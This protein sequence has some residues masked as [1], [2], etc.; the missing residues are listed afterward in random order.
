MTKVPITKADVLR[1]CVETLDKSSEEWM[2]DSGI[3]METMQI[4]CANA[5]NVFQVKIVTRGLTQGFC[6][7]VA[8]AFR[9]GFEVGRELGKNK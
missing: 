1:V 2:E 8:N 7:I 4:L 9:T 3:D 6:E 5:W